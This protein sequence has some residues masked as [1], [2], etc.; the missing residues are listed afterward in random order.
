MPD[1]TE[2]LS[3]LHEAMETRVKELTDHAHRQPDFMKINQATVDFIESVT[4][5][6][7]RSILLKYEEFKNEYIGLIMPYL[8]EAGARDSLKLYGLLYKQIYT[9]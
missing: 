6:E 3:F 8:Y 1:Q 7:M 2:L 4:D 9:D 5:E